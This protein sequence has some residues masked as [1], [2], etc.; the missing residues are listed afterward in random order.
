MHKMHFNHLDYWNIDEPVPVY[1]SLYFQSKQNIPN[2]LLSLFYL[3]IY[4]YESSNIVIFIHIL[5]RIFGIPNALMFIHTHQSFEL[6]PQ[7]IPHSPSD[8]LPSEDESC[9]LKYMLRWFGV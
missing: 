8:H 3:N 4:Q 5:L 1:G 2:S 7:H 6:T 9:P